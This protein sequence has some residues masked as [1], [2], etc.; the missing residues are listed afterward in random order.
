MDC[1]D[2]CTYFFHFSTKCSS[3]VREEDVGT[4]DYSANYCC[5]CWDIYDSSGNGDDNISSYKKE[6]SSLFELM[7]SY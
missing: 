5:Y 2:K 4:A 3:Q 7:T 1:I 6:Q